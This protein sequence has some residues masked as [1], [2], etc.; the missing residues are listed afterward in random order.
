M[1]GIEE[2]Q[3]FHWGTTNVNMCAYFSLQLLSYLSRSRRE[4]GSMLMGLLFISTFSLIFTFSAVSSL[5]TLAVS[6]V[7]E[8]TDVMQSL[9]LSTLACWLTCLGAGV[10]EGCLKLD[11]L[12]CS[13]FSVACIHFQM[14]LKSPLLLSS[15]LFFFCPWVLTF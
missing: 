10:V 3:L 12:S 8:S 9:N 11:R 13:L 6:D 4:M 5:Q 14:A 7:Q 1:V 15:L 2:I